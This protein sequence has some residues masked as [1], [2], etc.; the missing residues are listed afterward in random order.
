MKPKQEIETKP[1][2]TFDIEAKEKNGKWFLWKR[3]VD[4]EENAKKRISNL[5]KLLVW[6]ELRLLE[7]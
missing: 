1:H 4:T 7:K 3:I 5:Q 6:S 2:K